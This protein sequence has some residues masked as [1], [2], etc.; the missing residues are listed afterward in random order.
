MVTIPCE[1]IQ[2]IINL[3]EWHQSI[4]PCNPTPPD[5]SFVRLKRLLEDMYAK[6]YELCDETLFYLKEAV[7]DA[8]EYTDKCGI[9]SEQ[10]S[11]LNEW[12]NN[13]WKNRKP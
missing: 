3:L 5:F 2:P 7:Y 9:D 12:V 6:H 8:Q 4:Y 13:Q 1:H 10:F 11:Q